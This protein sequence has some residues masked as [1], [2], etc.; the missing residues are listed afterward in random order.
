[1]LIE[2]NFCKQRNR[3]IKNLLPICTYL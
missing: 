1:M 3:A 2:I